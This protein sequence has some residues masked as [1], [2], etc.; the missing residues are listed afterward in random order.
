MAICRRGSQDEYN[1][2]LRAF[3]ANNK[4]KH[5]SVHHLMIKG[6]SLQQAQNAVHVYF[7]GGMTSATFRLSSQDRNRLMDGFDATHKLPKD[8]VYHLMEHG[9]SYH[10]ATSA[11]YQYRIERGLIHT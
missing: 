10:Q 11:V 9:C 8:C 1:R 2:L 6:Y 5:T 7:K 4:P 3:D